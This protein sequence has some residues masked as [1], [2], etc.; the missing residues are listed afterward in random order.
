MALL[1]PTVPLPLSAPDSEM[2]SE[3]ERYIKIGLLCVQEA[4]ENRPDM[5]VVVAMLNT[6]NSDIN[7]LPRAAQQTVSAAICTRDEEDLLS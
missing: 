4:S 7:L 1:D 5:S 2:S 6:Q 3:I